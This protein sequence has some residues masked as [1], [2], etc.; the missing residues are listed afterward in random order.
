MLLVVSPQGTLPVLKWPVVSQTCYSSGWFQ[1]A[2]GTVPHIALGH[3]WSI[4][5]LNVGT[6]RIL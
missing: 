3:F 6:S 1:T 5:G 2:R 4:D